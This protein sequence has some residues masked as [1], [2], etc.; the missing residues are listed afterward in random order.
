MGN[1]LIGW[2]NAVKY[3]TLAAGSSA[4]RFPIENL[5]N[6]IGAASL[7]WQTESG[8]TTSYFTVTF[9]S[10]QT[11]RALAI[12]QTNLTPD[13]V[14]TFSLYENPS[15][16]LFSGS[17][18]S[19]VAGFGQSVLVADQDYTADYCRVDIADPGNPDSFLNV[20]LAFVGAGWL[21]EIGMAWETT[22]GR[23]R[24]VDDFRTIG[25]Q[26]YPTPRWS[27]RSR[28]VVLDWVQGDELWTDVGELDRISSLGGNVLVIPNIQSSEVSNEAIFGIV[29]VV[30]DISYQIGVADCF[31]WTFRIEERL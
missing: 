16:L 25:G 27:A 7:G 18:S 26:R 11:V 21:P 6:D 8:A 5:Q 12:C 9:P 22:F 2:N 30:N 15:T 14:I 3:A 23:N 29:E 10:S 20:S 19:I 4:T 17:G 13:A 28:Q 1:T 31:K 24:R